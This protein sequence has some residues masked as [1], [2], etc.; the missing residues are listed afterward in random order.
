MLSVRALIDGLKQN[1]TFVSVVALVLSGLLLLTVH[2]YRGE[3]GETK[4]EIVKL[5][6]A[7]FEWIGKDKDGLTYFRKRK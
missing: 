6:E 1:V 7:G 3:G 4:K 5:L 2:A